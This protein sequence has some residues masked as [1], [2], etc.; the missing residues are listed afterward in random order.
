[1]LFRSC[2]EFDHMNRSVKAQLKYAD[3]IGAR[4]VAVIGESELATG[5]VN[6]K[7]M[8]DGNVNS[9]KIAE[10]EEYLK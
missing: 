10:I 9:V 7:A 5:T 3:K 8:K 2:A 6:L 4:Y 1:M